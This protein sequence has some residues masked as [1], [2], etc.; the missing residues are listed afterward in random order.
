MIRYERAR[1]KLREGKKIL[2]SV[3]VSPEGFVPPFYK[4][5]QEGERAVKKEGFDFLVKNP[6]IVNLRRGRSYS[7]RAIW[8]WPYGMTVDYAFR[9]FDEFLEHVWLRN[10]DLVRV[11]LHPQDLQKKGLFDYALKMIEELRKGRELSS[12]GEYLNAKI[13][14]CRNDK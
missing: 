9:I 7:S 14:F 6:E 3:G 12:F 8:F 1:I 5:S 10:N 4:I 2:R 13:S 11:D